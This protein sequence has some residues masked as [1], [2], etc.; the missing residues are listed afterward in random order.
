MRQVFD[1]IIQAAPSRTTILI[2]GESGTGKELVARSL[3]QNSPRADRAFITVNSGNLPPDLLES[4]LFGHVKGAFTGAVYPKKGLFELADKGTIFFDEIGN[5]PLETQAKLLRVIQEREFMRLG[6]VE[7]IK[8]DVRIIAATNV[9]LRRMMDEGRFR[10]DLYYRLHVITVQL[11]PLRERK[12][13]IP[14]LVQHF[15]EKYGEENQKPHLELTRRGARPA[16][17]LR[18]AGQRPRARERHRAR[19]RAVARARDRRRSGAGARA[20][21]PAGSRCRSSSCRRRASRSATSITDFEKRLIE[22][23]L[24]AAGGVQK[25]AA[26]LLHI[27]PTTLNEMI[28]RHDIRPRRKRAAASAASGAR[29]ARTT[30]G[31]SATRTRSPTTIERIPSDLPHRD[32]L[33]GLR[34]GRLPAFRSWANILSYFA[35]ITSHR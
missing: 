20:Q 35:R 31:S 23:T 8:V 34:A 11:P 24:E 14:L 25:R 13:D 19:G 4:N 5:I 21:Q 17:G 16:A 9:D 29:C 1:L 7:T 27:K 12:D 28:K 6:G 18:L 15:L 3:H 22:S 10:E 33:G 26:E 30:G 2:N 32:A